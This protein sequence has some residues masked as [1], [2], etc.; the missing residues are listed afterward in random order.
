MALWTRSRGEDH[1]LT[2]ELL[3][4]RLTGQLDPE[5]ARRIDAHLDVCRSCQAELADERRLR[6]A[7]LSVAPPESS[8]PTARLRRVRILAGAFGAAGAIA[9]SLAV[10]LVSL[11]PA[12]APP[13]QAIYRTLGDPAPPSR[14]GELVVVFD[15]ESSVEQMR[16]ALV[17][18][19]ARIVD[20]PTATGAYVLRIPRGGRAAALT[21]LR[22]SPGVSMAASLGDQE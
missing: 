3:P 22:D 7:V 16:A 19:H 18:A 13:R 9:A 5:E 17:R 11:Q 6:D 4:W 15:P 20:G 10:A 2:R 12:R 14:A 1:R 21:A 8:A